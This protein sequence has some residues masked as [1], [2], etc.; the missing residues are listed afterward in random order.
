MKHVIKHDLSPELAKRATEAAFA[1]YAERFANYNP[2]ADWSSD[3]KADISF[4]AKG[5]KITGSFELHPGEIEMNLKVPFLLK[6][7][8][9]RAVRVVEESIQ[10][11]VEKAKAGEV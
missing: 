8:T 3:T 6:P 1:T 11:W 5:V 4:S 7:F 9:G 2:T 10:E